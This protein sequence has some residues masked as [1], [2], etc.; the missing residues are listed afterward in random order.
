MP[1]RIWIYPIVNTLRDTIRSRTPGTLPA[2][3]DEHPVIGLWHDITRLAR[4]KV[5]GGHV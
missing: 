1:E 3:S 2:K 5:L 4:R